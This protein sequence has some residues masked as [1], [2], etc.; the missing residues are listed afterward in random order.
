MRILVVALTILFFGNANTA[1]AT[2][3]AGHGG[4]RFGYTR[5]FYRFSMSGPDIYMW[6]INNGYVPE[7]IGVLA[8]KE[9][10][11]PFSQLNQ[12]NS[13]LAY[14]E[15]EGSGLT[16][17]VGLALRRSAT[18]AVYTVLVTGGV[19]EERREKVKLRYNEVFL[20]VGYRGPGSKLYLGVAFDIGMFSAWRKVNDGKWSPWFYS[21]KILGGDV[22]AKT[23]CAAV[24]LV[25]SYDISYFTLRVYSQHAMMNPK[26]N[27]ES[28]KYTN[29]PWSQKVFPISH[30]G[31]GLMFHLGGE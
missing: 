14:T 8:I 31:L 22:T 7:D 21:F 15:F 24:S 27:S 3:P 28:G 23:P 10:K 5:G 4:L 18:D 19:E 30:I 2:S 17:E 16:A 20:T 13:L 29:I 11:E 1:S 6:R 25:A 26:L 12:F 9:V